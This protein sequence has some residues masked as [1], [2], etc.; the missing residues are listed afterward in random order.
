MN[1]LPTQNSDQAL[2]LTFV[3]CKSR[4]AE[5]LILSALVKVMYIQDLLQIIEKNISN[6]NSDEYLCA[7]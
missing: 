5:A 4:Q 2:Q 7:A 1:N 3:N 6:G